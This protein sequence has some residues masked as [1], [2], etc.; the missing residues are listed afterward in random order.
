[1][2]RRRAVKKANPQSRNKTGNQKVMNAAAAY[3][4][5]AKVIWHKAP[6]HSSCRYH[7]SCYVMS[8]VMAA[9]LGLIEPEIAPFDPSTPKTPPLEPNMK[10]IG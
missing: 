5:K 4:T 1:M 8:C 6:S 2:H 3:E 9:I 10:W 7:L